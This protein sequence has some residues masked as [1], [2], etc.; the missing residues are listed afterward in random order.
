MLHNE[1]II[2]TKRNDITEKAYVGSVIAL[3]KNGKKLLDF[4]YCKDQNIIMRSFQKPF[5]AYAF[6]KSGAYK[7][8]GITKRELAVIS[9][10]HA[11]TQKQTELVESVLKKSGLKIGDLRC[12]KEYPLDE[13]AKYTLIKHGK[14]P[15]PIYCNCSGKH[16]GIL[17]SC[18]ALRLDIKGY[19]ES[20]HPIEEKITSY[21]LEL[22]EFDKKILAK[23]GCGV[24]VL[25][26]PSKNM[27]K[28]L[29]NLYNTNEGA[30]IISA[31]LKYPMLFGGN[32]RFDTEIIKLT[33]G[34]VFAKVG[35]CGLVGA[36]NT[37][38]QETLIVKIFADDH[39][40]R[41]SVTLDYM[42][43]LKWI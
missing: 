1:V 43:R 12:P 23:D 29:L 20:N 15:A 8:Y 22:C 17:S 13:K 7:K 35:A 5:Q 11:G 31:C 27:A 19:L 42:K 38:T 9:G 28:G 39:A 14:K 2:E 26:M 36:I 6:I 33:N 30:E 37:Q 32:N 24:P 4:S 10:S 41:R 3:D 21:T 40:A 16:A 34:K 18:M 25:A